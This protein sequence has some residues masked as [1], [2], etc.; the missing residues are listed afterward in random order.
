[1]GQL[2][3]KKKGTL[4]QLLV[5]CFQACSWTSRRLVGF[6]TSIAPFCFKSWQVLVLVLA[7]RQ[8]P[9]QPPQP[10]QAPQGP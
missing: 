10:Q 2:Q 5:S 6:V 3:L 8:L 4:R 7:A 9:P 1:M